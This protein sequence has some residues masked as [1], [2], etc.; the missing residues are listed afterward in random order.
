MAIPTDRDLIQLGPWPR[1]AN[2]LAPETGVPLGSFR[3]G[4]NVD[5][6]DGGTVSRR[7]GY[8]RVIA[9]DEP[10]DLFGY[11]DRGFF[12]SGSTLYG[13][14]VVNGQ[15]TAP[16]PL[17][18]QIRPD[19]RIAHCLV[20]PDIFVSDGEVTLRISPSNAVAP[21]T[22]AA[23]PTPVLTTGN[24]G[25]L[26]AGAYHVAVALKAPT[27]EEGPLGPLA[28]AEVPDN[29][30]L[31][32]NLPA[33]APGMRYAVYMTK[34]NGTELL[35]LV[36]A[37]SATINVYKQHQGRRPPTEDTDPLPAGHFAL[38]WKGRLL[39]AKDNYV[40][41]SEPMQYGLTRL[42]YNYLVLAEPV[43]MLAAVE[44]ADGFFIG[45]G[46]RTYLAQGADPA[47]ATLREVY[48][49]GVVA[50]TLQY[51]PGARLPMEVPPT[52]RCPM[53]TSTSGVFCVGLPDGSVLPL[54]ETRYAAAIASEGAALFVQNAGKNRYIATLRDPSENGFVLSDSFSAEVIRN[55]N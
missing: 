37:P 15:L 27:G 17:Y 40:F 2:N 45:Q 50:G 38:L 51:V 21:W 20:D 55:G 53:W 5:V 41:W 6:S 23:G 36:T 22:V 12:V 49:A 33:P 7:Q 10:H 9:V 24:A 19:A 30:S 3:R 43:T 34:P 29:G 44:T 14:E 28:K 8:T 25:S 32:V 48:P 42:A 16:I 47:D 39:V 31:T 54:T 1:G 26:T 4:V 11:G 18:D 13:F 52:E 46:S 35:H